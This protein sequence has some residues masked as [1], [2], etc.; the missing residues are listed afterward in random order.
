M[1][2][3]LQ[4]RYAPYIEKKSIKYKATDLKSASIRF[5]EAMENIDKQNEILKT[6]KEK[7]LDGER[8]V[9]RAQVMFLES[10]LDYY[11]H[12][13]VKYGIEKMFS[14][15]PNWPETSDFK[16]I[17]VSL[18]FTKKVF[19]QPENLKDIFNELDYSLPTY[20]KYDAIIRSLV[21]IGIYE[22]HNI[23]HKINNYRKEIN[24]ISNR[25]NSIVHASDR[26]DSGKQKYL[27]ENMVKKFISTICNFQ[28]DIQADIEYKNSKSRVVSQ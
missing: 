21:M 4:E 24:E 5:S 16:K 2:K 25:R 15:H 9:L 22:E 20:M 18:L 23:P 7:H 17:K 19:N 1:I 3:D 6:L 26:T 13:I 10:A 12:E 14:N 8:D 27:D 28:K 11:V